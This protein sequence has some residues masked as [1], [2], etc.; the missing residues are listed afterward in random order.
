LVRVGF[1]LI[2]L[3]RHI[4]LLTLAMR[5]RLERADVNNLDPVAFEGAGLMDVAVEDPLDAEPGEGFGWDQVRAIA[6]EIP[7]AEGGDGALVDLTDHLR[8]GLP[9]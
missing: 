8:G 1:E 3:D 6:V 5:K 4:Q 9:G 7:V 2:Q